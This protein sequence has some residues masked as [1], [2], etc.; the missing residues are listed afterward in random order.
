M[1]FRDLP[2]FPPLFVDFVE[3]AQPARTFFGCPTDAESLRSRAAS[4]QTRLL[5]R[6][7]LCDLLLAQAEQFGS[8]EAALANIARLRV[9]Q[10]V[11]VAV[12]LRP[13]LFGGPL[14]SWLKALT[15]ARLAAWLD[16]DGRPAVPVA[17]IDPRIDPACLSVGLFASGSLQR[18]NLDDRSGPTVTV[19]DQIKDLL[20]R[21]ALA[22][23]VTA[24]DSDVLRLL[25]T[26][27]EPGKDFVL[28]WGQLISRFLEPCGIILLDPRQN[29]LPPIM[30]SLPPSI[31]KDKIAALLAKQDKH[32]IAAGYGPKKQHVEGNQDVQPLSPLVGPNLV[33]PVAANVMDASEAYGFARNQAIFGELRLPPPVIWPAVSA[34]LLEARD[35]KV[36][37][38]YGIGI[39]KLFMGSSVITNN[40]MKQ[41]S[42]GE[43]QARMDGLRAEVEEHLANL[44]SLVPPADKLRQGIEKSRRRMVYQIDKLRKRLSDAEMRRREAMVRQ[45]SRLCDGLAPWGRLQEREFAA[46]QFVQRHSRA[47]PQRLCKSIDPWKF[48]HQLILL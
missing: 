17:W 46:F 10:T 3:G 19:P 35:R 37:A 7:E 16:H 43:Q 24:G 20:G 34:T 45:I 21:I 27:Y 42:V 15:A 11:A 12:T 48:E 23:D 22:F 41:M 25:E 39:E 32:L 6:R 28:A 9:P 29:G 36:L 18:F 1:R 8:G 2:G 44:A 31:D 33:L 40:L 5:P 26:A 30:R 47:L 14:C 38:R 4:S 13:E